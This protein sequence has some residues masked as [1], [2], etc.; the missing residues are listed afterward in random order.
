MRETYIKVK[1]RDVS[2]SHKGPIHG[3]D[4]ASHQWTWHRSVTEASPRATPDSP[5]T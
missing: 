5:G 3:R 2:V 1:Y 4:P